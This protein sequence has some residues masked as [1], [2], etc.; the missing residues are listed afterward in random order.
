L[1]A[2]PPQVRLG[3]LGARAKLWMMDETN[4]EEAMLAPEAFRARS[5]EALPDSEGVFQLI[6]RPYAIARIDTLLD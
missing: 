5:G 1:G 3:I 6:L 2:D 4:A